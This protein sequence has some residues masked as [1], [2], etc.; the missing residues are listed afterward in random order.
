MSSKIVVEAL[1]RT[2]AWG[3]RHRASQLKKLI[4]GRKAGS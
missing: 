2:T 1:F 4:S 3:I